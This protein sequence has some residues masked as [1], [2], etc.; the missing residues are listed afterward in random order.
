MPLYELTHD[1]LTPL[2]PTTMAQQDFKE[3]ADLQRLLKTQIEIIDKDLLVLAEEFS[4]WEGSNRRIDLLALDKQADLVVI[5]LKRTDDGAFMDL[6]A[7]R[8]AAMV[9]AMTFQQAVHEHAKFLGDPDNLEDARLRIL[10]FLE[11]DSP[12]E[13]FASEVR[14][15]LASAD[16]S[17]ELTTAVLWLNNSGLNIRCV[18]LRPHALQSRTILEV[19]QVIPVPGEE[20]MTVRLKEKQ[21][22]NKQAKSKWN[23]DTSHYDLTVGDKVFPNLTKRGLAWQLVRSA[24]D[25]GIDF[26]WLKAQITPYRLLA[27]DGERSSEEFLEASATAKSPSGTSFDLGR[28]FTDDGQLF[29]VGGKTYALSNQWSIANIPQLNEIIARLP[30]GTMSYAK[31]EPS[32]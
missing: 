28:F 29:V 23:I 19:Q 14:I 27:I 30:A 16:F 32:R 26:E 18:R 1:A 21:E 17:K 22:E 10:K 3:R 15:I 31:A 20:E 6:Q 2:L 11:W 13:D 4:Q 25:E 5:E 12:S 8:Y 24:I 9:R 7:I